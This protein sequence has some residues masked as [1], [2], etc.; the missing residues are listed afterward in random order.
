MGRADIEDA[1]RGVDMGSCPRRLCYPRG[2][3]SVTSSPHRE[4]HEGSLGPAFASASFA[5]QDSVRPAFGLTLYAEFLS[6]LSR[7]LG[8][9][10]TFSRACR[11]SRTAHLALSRGFPRLGIQSWKVGV[12]LAPSQ[13]PKGLVLTAPDYALQPQPHPSTKLQ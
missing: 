10:D 4:G 11:P 3:F 1:S 5:F 13:P 8:T 2:N 12:A 9:L 7:P 6:R